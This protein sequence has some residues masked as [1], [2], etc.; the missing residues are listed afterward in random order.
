MLF[1]C[2]RYFSLFNTLRGSDSPTVWRPEKGDRTQLL[3]IGKL[4]EVIQCSLLSIPAKVNEPVSVLRIPAETL[5]SKGEQETQTLA[6]TFAQGNIAEG[7]SRINT[8]LNSQLP[9]HHYVVYDVSGVRQILETIEDVN[10]ELPVGFQV[11]HGETDY[12]FA[13]GV[14]TINSANIVPFIASESA[15][16]AVNFWAEKSLLVEVFNELFSLNHISYLV[17][18]MKT[19]SGAYQTDMSS[20]ELARFRDTLQAMDWNDTSFHALPGRW[21]TAEDNRYWSTDQR[22]VGLMVQQILGEISPYNRD[23]L[24]VDV[25]NGNGVNGFAA[26]TATQLQDQQYRVGLVGNADAAE[27]TLIYYQAEY[28]L[29]ALELAMLLEVEAVLVEDSYESSNNPVAVIL[30]RDLI[31]R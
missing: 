7:I 10:V 26:R 3:L 31:G 15:V 24:V 19:V 14:N 20:K 2:I 22:I 21:L 17:S 6:D 30:G 8:L 11:H 1:A 9:I 12:V 5:L 16:E 28:K 27:T 25:F 4:D 29:A 23:E 18:N 13:P